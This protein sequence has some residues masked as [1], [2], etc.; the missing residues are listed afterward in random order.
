MTL[1]APFKK[2]EY[3]TSMKLYS[4]FSVYNNRSNLTFISKNTK[5]S[6]MKTLTSTLLTFLFVLIA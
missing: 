2:S 1:E 4:Y 5:R 6:E 3:S